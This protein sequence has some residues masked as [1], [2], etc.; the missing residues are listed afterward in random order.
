MPIRRLINSVFA[1][2]I[3]AATCSH[4]A[5]KPNVL[6]IC[7]DDLR[8]ELASFGKS[9]IKS[10]NIDK[11]AATGRP[12]FRH[13][14]QAPTCG[15]SRYALLTGL[16]GG[17]SN[18]ALF[19]RAAELKKKPGSLPPTMPAWFRTHGYTARS[20]I[21]PVVEVAGTGT[22]TRNPRCRTRGI[23]TCFPPATGIIPGARCMAWLMARSA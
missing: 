17:P 23:V 8:P 11:L 4:A 2:V 22:T 10:P 14:V 20:L 13:Y 1:F 5:K 6:L 19:T 3:F 15:A 18:N 12:F 7:I 16:Y 9:Y 21:I